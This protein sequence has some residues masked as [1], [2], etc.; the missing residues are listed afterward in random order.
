M[1]AEQTTTPKITVPTTAMRDVIEE[2][3]IM[4]K[5][6]TQRTITTLMSGVTTSR[7]VTEIP[8]SSIRRNTEAISTTQPISTI[9]GTFCQ[10]MTAEQT[11]TPEITIPMTVPQYF[12]DDKATVARSDIPRTTT[13]FI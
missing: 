13:T 3:S 1:T 12:T 9:P 4:T 8:T 10:T 5:N 6:D 7:R 11:E 2:T